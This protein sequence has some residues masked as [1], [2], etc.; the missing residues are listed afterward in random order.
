MT[1]EFPVG[2]VHGTVVE[3]LELARSG[4]LPTG[5][6]FRSPRPDPTAVLLPSGAF[7]EPEEMEAFALA[8]GYPCHGLDTATLEDV[9]RGLFQL[10][11][12]PS[13][14]DYLRAYDYYAEFDAFLPALDAPDPPPVDEVLLKMDRDFYELLGRECDGASCRAE[15]CGRGRVALSVFCRRHH[16]ESVKKRPCPF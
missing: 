8:A 14:A 7:D 2:T 3:F 6:L 11:P 12:T 15:G 13:E 4:T 10:T 1:G 16:F 5:W 9:A